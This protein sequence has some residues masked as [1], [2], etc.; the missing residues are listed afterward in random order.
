MTFIWSIR[1]AMTMSIRVVILTFTSSP[2]TATIRAP[3]TCRRTRLQSSVADRSPAARGRRVRAR[4]HAEPEGLRRLAAPVP[5]PLR[6]LD[7]LVALDDDQRVRARDHGV[8][9]RP[10]GPDRIGSIER[11]MTSSGTSG[12]TASWTT[13]TSSSAAVERRQAVAGALV[14]GRAAGDDRHRHVERR[15]LDQLAGLVDPAGVGD[16]DHA[17]DGRG[18]ER[19]QRSQQD[20]VAGEPDELLRHLAAEPVAVAAGEDD[21][22]DLHTQRLRQG[23]SRDRSAPPRAARH[24]PVS[25][26][27]SMV[28][29]PP[30]RRAPTGVPDL[31]LI[32]VGWRRIQVLLRV[33]PVDAPLDPAGLR[34]RHATSGATV[35]VTG[36]EADDDPP[37]PSGST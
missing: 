14:A 9:R 3:G 30:V 12:R 33:R 1:S 24:P 28:E 34:L 29:H 21:R 37:R 16:D 8:G 36:W 20:R 19:P 25:S 32:S 5:A 27:P 2:A 15:R 18:A 23:A 13:T 35:P 22:V 11:W 4:E 6:D 17:V 7:D 10:P 26:V 31:E